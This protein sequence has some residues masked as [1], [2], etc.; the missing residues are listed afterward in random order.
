MRTDLP[1]GT[2]TFLFTDIEGSTQLLG[3]L[4]DDAY[5]RALAEHGRIL[6]Q[7]FVARG[8]IEVDTQGDA[9]FVAFPSAS[10]AVE[11]ARASQQVLAKGPM[12]VRMAL[13][14]ARAHLAETGY[15]GTDVHKASRISAVAHGGQVLM[16]QETRHLLS[17]EVTDLGEHRLKDFALPVPIFQLGSERF[18]PLKTISNT[19]LPHPASSFVGREKEVAEIRSLIRHGARLVTLTGP[20]GTGKTRLGIEAAVGLV[21]EFKAG[22]FW[23]PLAAVR[24][25]A[26]VAETI[27]HSLGAKQGLA[28][29]I[30]E[31]ELLLVLD[32]LEQVVRAAPGMAALVQTCPN[33]HILS[34]SRERLRVTGE[35]EFAVSP[36][37]DHEAVRLFCQRAAIEPDEAVDELC[38]ALENLPLALELAAARARVLSPQAI[39]DRIATRLDL[40]KG[41]RDADPRQ[42]TLR[43]G[44]EWSHELLTPDEQQLF[45]R[46]AVFRGGCSLAA[47]EDVAGADIDTLQSLVE[48]SLV[49]YR[50]DRYSMLET[51]R[52]YAA[53]RLESTGDAIWSRHAEYFIALAE[54]AYPH[55]R[56][57]PVPWLGLLERDHDNLRAALER[58]QASGDTQSALQLAGALYGFWYLRSHIQE[59]QRSL[60]SALGA[61]TR[62]TPARARALTGASV[63]ALSLANYPTATYFAEESLGLY[64]ELGDAWGT[65]Y[66][67]FQVA[68]SLGEGGDVSRARPLFE[69]SRQRFRELGDDLHVVVATQ[70]M[71]WVLYDLGDH[72]GSRALLEE[73]LSGA[74]ALA[75]DRVV[76]HSLSDLSNFARDESRLAEA[77]SMLK[78]SIRLFRGIGL[79]EEIAI[80]LMRLAR[81]LALDG[82]TNHAARI[83][84]RSEALHRE[85][86]GTMPASLQQSNDSTVTAIRAK[87]DELAFAKASDEGRAMTIDG[88]L[89]MA[90]ES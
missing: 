48:K 81:V 49:R 24:E 63:M 32:N 3:E 74:R 31:R 14:T 7:E 27:A 9:F 39:L 58:L 12:R 38:H 30:G 50:D 70:N 5:G 29:H 25:P 37:A 26:L 40:L 8:G 23:V 56:A 73:A 76:A 45:R 15:I 22:V 66:A 51:I 84:A 67:L 17:V 71:A 57:D 33:L 86:G 72:E 10:G 89:G 34:T 59:G 35:V 41:G 80:T 64:R 18:P 65:A 13:H 11:A 36:L 19:N 21:A 2:I 69:D 87:M 16:S 60:E 53:E 46:L 47:A 55:L 54:Q 42:Q 1:T 90:L 62:P 82:R 79:L 20:G 61:D 83:L 6:R 44:M 43:A 88:I 52:E 85:L 78:E 4:G 28:E 77:C 68:R 75:N